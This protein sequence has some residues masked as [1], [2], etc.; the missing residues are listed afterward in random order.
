[1][2]KLIIV[3]AVFA[4][5]TGCKNKTHFSSDCSRAVDLVAPWSELGIPL[6]DNIRVCSANDLK[7]DLEYL[8]G[9]KPTW[10]QEYEKTLLG[11]GYTKDR[12]SSTSCTYVKATERITV[13]VN[14]VAAG[15]KAK[16]IV[17][18]NRSTAR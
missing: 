4:F 1:M 14:Q 12:C 17:H 18:L 5:T 3:C 7:V 16:T 8:V 11:K 13:Q 6:G 9:D 15:K 2:R 10:E